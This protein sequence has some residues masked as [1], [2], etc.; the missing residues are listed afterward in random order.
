MLRFL[1]PAAAAALLAG[2]AS[3][4]PRSD[5]ANALYRFG[6][7]EAAYELGASVTIREPEASRLIS[8]RWIAAE[9]ETGAMRIVRTVQWSDRST[10]LMQEAVLDL[11]SGEGGAV[12]LPAQAGASTDFEF[13]WR[14]SD[15]TLKGGTARCRL[16][17]TILKG[18]DRAVFRQ[19]SISTS[20]SALGR[21]DA[22]RAEALVEAG[23]AC[24][25]EAAAF[26]AEATKAE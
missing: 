19:T 5:P 22:S 20:A 14:I 21:T 9:D 16:E 4:I 10:S 3:V 8:G 2:C 18:Q 11:L 26:I 17:A 7:L 25:R 6:P 23:R 13:S 15:L 1:I 12:A 24:A